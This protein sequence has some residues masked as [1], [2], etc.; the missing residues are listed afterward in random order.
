MKLMIP[1][2]G[3]IVAAGSCCCCGFDPEEL[4]EEMSKQSGG[5]TEDVVVTDGG[6]ADEPASGGGG[7]GT[8]EGTCGRFK[9]DGLSLPSGLSV[10]N[11]ATSSGTESL[12][13][14]GSGS[15]KDACGGIKSWATGKG[16]AVEYDV[17]AGG[18]YSITLKNG[19]ERMAIACTD[20][21]GQTTVSVSITPG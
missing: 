18:S 11:C 9:A 21:T 15:P 1:V 3:M 4:M 14:M 17:E 20:S 5:G 7:G 16:W 10:L 13:A 6:E 2:V 19:G 12:V 8:T